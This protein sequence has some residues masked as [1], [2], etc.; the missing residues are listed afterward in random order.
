MNHLESGVISGESGRDRRPAQTWTLTSVRGGVASNHT[1][2]SQW[3]PLLEVPHS[4][5]A[6]SIGITNQFALKLDARHVRLVSGLGRV[7]PRQVTPSGVRRSRNHGEPAISVCSSSPAE[8]L[9]GTR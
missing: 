3:L 4:R 9:T 6:E 5:A 1:S 7:T 2:V 8:P